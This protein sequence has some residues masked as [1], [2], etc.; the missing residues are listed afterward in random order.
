MIGVVAWVAWIAGGFGQGLCH[1]NTCCGER[2]SSKKFN[3]V[4][5]T[6]ILGMSC[7]LGVVAGVAGFGSVSR[8][9]LGGAAGVT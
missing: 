1:G 4:G 6:G 9:T 7:T 3:L 8:G 5:T 2:E